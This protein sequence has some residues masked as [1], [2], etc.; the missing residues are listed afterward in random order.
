[1]ARKRDAY[2]DTSALI[3]FFDRSDA[4]H[5]LFKRLF[6]A[7][8]PFET[9]PL[10][11]AEGHAWVLRKYD[12]SR[13]RSFLHLIGSLPRLTVHSIGHA[14]QTSAETFL[15]RF[16]DQDL[17]LVDAVGLHHAAPKALHLLVDRL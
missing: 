17:T 13:A 8:P 16:A 7:P 1:M 3:A 12:R 6:A 15:R 11:A 10:V 14:E 9:T 4:H 2:V 5:Q